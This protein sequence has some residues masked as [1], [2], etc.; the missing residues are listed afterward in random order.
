MCMYLFVEVRHNH[1]LLCKLCVHITGVV[2]RVCMY[3]YKCLTFLQDC[4]H[5]SKQDQSEIEQQ[6]SLQCNPSA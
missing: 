1:V 6:R 5:H 3:V 4:E 2:Y